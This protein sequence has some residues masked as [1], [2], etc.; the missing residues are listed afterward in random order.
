MRTRTRRIWIE[1][2]WLTWNRTNVV[3][4]YVAVG[5][6]GELATRLSSDILIDHCL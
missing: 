2:R 1:R 6:A 4:I 5:K 3:V